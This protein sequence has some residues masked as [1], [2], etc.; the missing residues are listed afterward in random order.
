MYSKAS[1]VLQRIKRKILRFFV[2]RLLKIPTPPNTSH[3]ESHFL[4][5]Q[6]MFPP[7][8]EYGYD[9]FSTW[10]RAVKRTTFAL[11]QL[12]IREPGMNILDAACGDGMLGVLLNSYGHQTLL[13][14]MEDW[15]DIRAK[16][17]PFY[18]QR[19]EYL[20]DFKSNQFDLIFSF[21]SFEH[22]SDPKTAFNELLRVCKPGGNIYLEFGPL[23]HG[24][25]GL[26]AHR[27]L[28]MPYPQFLFLEE[29]TNRKLR[30]LGID[31]LGRKSEQLQPLNKWKYAD[32]TRL[33]AENSLC[34]VVF[35]KRETNEDHLQ[36]VIRYF[37]AFRGRNI[38]YLDLTTQGISV[39]IQKNPA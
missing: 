9:K 26:H 31:D 32:F 5:L 38:D 12:N 10:S 36:V 39:F 7:L 11:N 30:E 25:W 13:T 2:A 3:P 20:R 17:L 19:L 15:R 21:N 29:F 6:E 33:W 18:Q 28:R 14:D 37:R 4:Y 34:K 8:P 1:Y 27:S 24:P 22:L 16:P 23:Y 35:Q